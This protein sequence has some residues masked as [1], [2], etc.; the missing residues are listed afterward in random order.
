MLAQSNDQRPTQ[1]STHNRRD[2][3]VTTQTATHKGA[4]IPHTTLNRNNTHRAHTGADTAPRPNIYCIQ[5]LEVRMLIRCTAIP[6]ADDDEDS[7]RMLPDQVAENHSGCGSV[8]T[9]T[10]ATNPAHDTRPCQLRSQRATSQADHSSTD[11][12]PDTRSN[13]TSLLPQGKT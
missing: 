13:N 5:S 9:G 2:G 1:H 6:A 7:W 4:G 3:A 11:M 12:Q 8:P 10:K